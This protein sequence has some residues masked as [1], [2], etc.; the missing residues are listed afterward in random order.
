MRT[1]QQSGKACVNLFSVDDAVV[2][3]VIGDA[4]E[5]MQGSLD[6]RVLAGVDSLR[7]TYQEK[8]RNL[9]P[10]TPGNLVGVRRQ[11]TVC[12]LDVRPSDAELDMATLEQTVIQP[13]RISFL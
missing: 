2:D 4:A 9:F 1:H 3:C 6:S 13:T 7:E 11:E 8:V 5:W 12:V 10:A